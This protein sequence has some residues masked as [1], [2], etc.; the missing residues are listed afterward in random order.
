MERIILLEMQLKEALDR[1][2]NLKKLNDQIMSAMNEFSK[3][4]KGRDSHLLK[5][6]HD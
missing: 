6:M 5:K 1:E 3:Q 4:D 2:Q